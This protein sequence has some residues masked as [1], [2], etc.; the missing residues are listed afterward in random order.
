MQAQYRKDYAGEF[1]VVETKYTNGK[2]EQTR[3]WIANPIT[4]QHLTAGAVCI[5]VGLDTDEFNYQVLQNH[6]GGLLGSKKLQ[7]YGSGPTARSM[8]LDFAVDLNYDNLKPLLENG[9]TEKN[10]VYTT[11]RNCLRNPG[12][13]YLIP[14]APQLAI[15][16]LPLYL[17][18]FDQHQD[19]YMLGY[20]NDTEFSRTG[21]FQQITD[22]IN[23]YSA[24]RFTM[25]G[26]RNNMPAEWLRCSNTRNFTYQEFIVHCDI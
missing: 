25:V 12:E 19:I 2:K 18:G 4:N 20:S 22:I 8:R 14:Q 26:N 5:N 10:V 13:F 9:Y 17:A 16:A 7:T 11:A 3:E 21:A 15:E 24:T 1:V 6:H 23:A